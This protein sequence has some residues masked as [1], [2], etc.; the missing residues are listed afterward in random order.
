VRERVRVSFLKKGN[1]C[2]VEG[3]KCSEGKD[4]L[5]LIL[6]D[7]RGNKVFINRYMIENIERI[8]E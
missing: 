1:L 6:M 8:E 5:K 2:V 4:P 7:D 3:Y